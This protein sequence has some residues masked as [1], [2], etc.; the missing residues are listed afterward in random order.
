MAQGNDAAAE[1]AY[2]ML[3]ALVDEDDSVATTIRKELIAP[4]AQFW[5]ACRLHLSGSDYC[6]RRQKVIRLRCQ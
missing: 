2:E 3:V 1:N 4:A 6:F 5:K